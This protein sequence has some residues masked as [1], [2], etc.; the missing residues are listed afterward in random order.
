MAIEYDNIK[1]FET[2]ETVD[3]F[4][5]QPGFMA[6]QYE[7]QIPFSEIREGDFYLSWYRFKQFDTFLQWDKIGIEN[8]QLSNKITFS[9]Y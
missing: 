7:G 6:L 2:R 1:I 8:Y 3:G 9:S 5:F 4:T